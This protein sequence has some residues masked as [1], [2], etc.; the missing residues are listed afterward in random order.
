MSPVRTRP[1]FALQS[2]SAWPASPSAPEH[3]EPTH[4]PTTEQYDGRHQW[5]S[6]GVVMAT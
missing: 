5:G 1:A 2:R 6:T 3:D 4:D